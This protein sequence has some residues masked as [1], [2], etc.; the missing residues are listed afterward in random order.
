[1]S[2]VAGVESA[3]ADEPPVVWFPGIVSASLIYGQSILP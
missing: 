2:R 1:M 3:A